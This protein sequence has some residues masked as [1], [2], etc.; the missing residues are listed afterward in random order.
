MMIT[1]EKRPKRFSPSKLQTCYVKYYFSYIEPFRF[2]TITYP[3]ILGRITHMILEDYLS[4]N[5][6]DEEKAK[7]IQKNKERLINILIREEILKKTLYEEGFIKDESIIEQIKMDEGQNVIHILDDVL[8]NEVWYPYF[9]TIENEIRKLVS[10]KVIQASQKYFEK[11]RNYLNK[12]LLKEIEIQHKIKPEN[13]RI[14]SEI[15]LTFTIDATNIKFDKSVIVYGQADIL[16]EAEENEKS[17]KFQVIDLKTGKKMP[18]PFQIY[19]YG[20]IL[21]KMLDGYS[22]DSAI[23]LIYLNPKLDSLKRTIATFRVLDKAITPTLYSK[24]LAYLSI[25]AQFKKEIKDTKEQYNN[26]TTLELFLKKLEEEIRSSNFKERENK[27]INFM[28]NLYG[29]EK[30]KIEKVIHNA[31]IIS[32]L[33]EYSKEHY[34]K[35]KC[36]FCQFKGICPLYSEFNY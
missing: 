21:S 28:N 7:N 8:S 19:T 25:E 17:H 15:P 3:I 35:S 27:F 12:N 11:T 23:S 6:Q 1:E 30:E 16:I 26:I 14:F 24:I 2:L 20:Q 33:N 32:A 9:K 29:Y 34:M 4:K 5:V 13:I 18:S 36:I 31:Q 22:E 10:D